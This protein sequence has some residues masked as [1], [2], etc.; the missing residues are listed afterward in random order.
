MRGTRVIVLSIVCA[1]VLFVVVTP[2]AIAEEKPAETNLKSTPSQEGQLATVN[3][4]KIPAG[5]KIFVAPMEAGFDNFIIAGFQKKNVPLVV[6]AD[7]SKAD[8]ELSGIEDS[9]KA[10]WAKMLFMGS[11]QSRE[12]GSV[13]ITDL[14]SGAVIFGYSVHKG[15]SYKGKQSAGEA[16][17]KHVKEIVVSK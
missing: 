15:N 12:Q 1:L 13:K 5:S 4:A 11:Q 9:E 14:K 17:A 7:K 16:C 10:G 2:T 6:V 8:Y 3:N